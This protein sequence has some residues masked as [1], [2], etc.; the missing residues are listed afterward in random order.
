M[1][2][3]APF[4]D[5]IVLRARDESAAGYTSY[6]ANTKAAKSA[7]D[8]LGASAAGGVRPHNDLSNAVEKSGLTAGETRRAFRALAQE[9]NLIGG[10]LGQ[11][12]RDTGILTVGSMRLGAGITVATVGIAAS[13][14]AIY[15]SVGAYVE[16]E[17][18][19]ATINNQLSLT[20][21]ASGET[22]ASLEDM[23]KRLRASGTQSIEGIRGAQQE[24]LKFKAVG[25]DAF[26]RVL[27]LSKDI[28]ATG[29][30]DLKTAAVAVA[31]AFKEPAKASDFLEAAGL[32]LS[33][34]EQRLVT[35]LSNAG[36]AAEA[37]RVMFNALSKQVAGADAVAADTLSGAWGRVT[38]AGGGTLE[39]WGKAIAEALRLKEGLDALAGALDG[40][41]KERPLPTILKV[42]SA[43]ANPV[44]AVAAYA[45]NKVLAPAP[46]IDFAN[47][48]AGGLDKQEEAWKKYAATLKVAGAEAAIAQRKIDL[49]T[50]ALMVQLRTAGMNTVELAVH[51]EALKAEVLGNKSAEAAIRRYVTAIEGA[52]ALRQISD[53]I[54]ERTAS[55]AIEGQTIGMTTIAATEYKMVQEAIAR[56]RIKGINLGS[57]AIAKLKEEAAAWRLVEQATAAAKLQEELKFERDQLGRSSTEQLVASRLKGAGLSA[58]SDTGRMLASTIRLND[59]LKDTKEIASEA[60]KGFVADLRAGKSASEALGNALD[61]IATKLIDKSIDNLVSAAIGGFSGLGGGAGL[62][63]IGGTAGLLAPIHHLGGVVGAGAMA[64]RY[65]HPAYFDNAPRFH[66]GGI[67]GDEVPLIAKK[68]EVVGWPDQM[69]RAF[70]GGNHT[71][72]VNISLDGA[73]GDEAVHRIAAGAA[74]HGVRLA[75]AQVPG[76]A[77]RAV[78]E[79]QARMN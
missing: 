30:V 8:A 59:A 13:T 37:Q 2:G 44:G 18:H 19:Q 74:A 73:N 10:P 7:T 52:K 3:G 57:G 16:L 27:K 45:T 36:R 64:Q 29:F 49:V 71:V 58:D 26:E 32:K 65:V 15:L 23:A 53:Q 34:A 21:S 5:D 43:L 75:L 54:K 66:S 50:D 42:M 6:I 61:K 60:L 41:S 24:L 78:T 63:N 76:I 20:K 35:D 28:A 69:A 11:M 62:G 38:A 22:A 33:V 4:V 39:V 51:N 12:I 17:K 79:H 40:L 25:G 72:N 70:G 48:D 9:A 31:S 14:A 56:E 68:G 47:Q 55:S 77:V 1:A 67:V 46:K